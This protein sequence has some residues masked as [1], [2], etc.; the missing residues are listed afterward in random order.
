MPPLS[1]ILIL[2][3][4]YLLL[5]VEFFV[6]SGGVIGVAAALAAIAAIVTAFLHSMTAG[7]TIFMLVTVTTPIIIGLMVHVW[8]NT[9]IG[10]KILN[11]KLGQVTVS[12]MCDRRLPNGNPLAS[13]VNQVGIAVTDLLPAG[14][15]Q[16]DGQRL[17]AVSIGVPIDAG[18]H[19]IVTQIQAGKIQVRPA[20]STEVSPPESEEV[21]APA[22]S[23]DLLDADLNDLG[24]DDLPTY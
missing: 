23:P 13:I 12:T 22:S 11:R 15:I 7:V 5:L 2:G 1:S 21:N 24:A 9:A 19:I 4:F 16:V 18:S 17:N 14:L 6:P 20:L 8:P 3:L 10:Q